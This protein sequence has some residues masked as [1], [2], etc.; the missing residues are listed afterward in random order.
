M[1]IQ[2]KDIRHKDNLIKIDNIHRVESWWDIY[3][4][5]KDIPVHK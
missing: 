1:L 4:C 3:H 2:A 5:I